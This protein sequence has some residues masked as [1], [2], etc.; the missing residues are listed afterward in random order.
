MSIKPCF[1]IAGWFAV[2]PDGGGELQPY[3]SMKHV[4]DADCRHFL[5][6]STLVGFLTSTTDD[7]DNISLLAEKKVYPGEVLRV[8]GIASRKWKVKASS[9]PSTTPETLLLK[10]VNREKREISFP[11]AHPGRF[12][13]IA[14]QHAEGDDRDMKTDCVYMIG[15][16]A[17]ICQLPLIV[18]LVFGW[19]PWL[20]DGGQFNGLLRLL[21]ADRPETLVMYNFVRNKDIFVELPV[22]L[23]VKVRRATNGSQYE[24]SA[25]YKTAL[26]TC[27]KRTF[28]FVSSIKS[29]SLVRYGG[30]RGNKQGS[31]GD[32]TGK[33]TME[34]TGERMG[35][36]PGEGTV[37]TTGEGTGE[38]TG[39]E[40]GETTGEDKGHSAK[41]SGYLPMAIN[42]DGF[43]PLRLFPPLDYETAPGAGALSFTDSE[44]NVDRQTSVDAFDFSFHFSVPGG[45]EL[46]KD[47]CGRHSMKPSTVLKSESVSPPLDRKRDLRE[48]RDKEVRSREA[49]C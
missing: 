47:T 10:C 25:A 36:I 24:S 6:V 4:A 41:R 14:E 43:N 33:I 17:E 31:T 39:E 21:G 34:G 26:A 11:L 15:D 35:Q 48:S 27:R 12:Y 32:G 18:R 3:V 29:A 1:F 42:M 23:D 19:T 2:E 28:P 44:N 9:K 30:R 22:G 38:T 46:R 8:V 20:L 40:T 16:I 45:Y 7:D 5:T 13:A 49:V 37:E